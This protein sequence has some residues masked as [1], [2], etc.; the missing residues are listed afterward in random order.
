MFLPSRVVTIDRT[1]ASSAYLVDISRQPIRQYYSSRSLTTLTWCCGGVK[2]A[3]LLDCL[4]LVS[5]TPFSHLQHCHVWR[6]YMR[7]RPFE[8][9]GPPYLW[10]VHTF[11]LFREESYERLSPSLPQYLSISLGT[12][13]CS[14]SEHVTTTTGS[15]EILPGYAK[16]SIPFQV[17]FND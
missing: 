12:F 2:A 11:L 14:G 17:L 3:F 1:M 8:A 13:M 7:T 15:N 4:R 16:V 10:A 5:R 9:P 6:N